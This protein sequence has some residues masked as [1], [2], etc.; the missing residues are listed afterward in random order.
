[1]VGRWFG[2][3]ERAPDLVAGLTSSGACGVSCRWHMG[4]N[5]VDT[6]EDEA[7]AEGDLRVARVRGE[8]GWRGLAFKAMA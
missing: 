7:L 2:T 4:E 8:P 1:M 6:V 5:L 3:G